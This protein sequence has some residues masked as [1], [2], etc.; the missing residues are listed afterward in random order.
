[1][2]DI[3]QQTDSGRPLPWK[4]PTVPGGRSACSEDLRPCEELSSAA[5][6]PRARLA[7]SSHVQTELAARSVENPS[8]ASHVAR[9]SVSESAQSGWVDGRT[10]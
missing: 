1:M 7:Y 4:T 3:N 8:S 10:P 2:A 5:S 9:S 6:E